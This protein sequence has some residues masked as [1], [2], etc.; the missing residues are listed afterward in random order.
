M[1]YKIKIFFLISF[2]LIPINSN[3]N[4]IYDKNN[5]IISTIDLNYY[6][7]L[8]FENYGLE[9]NES[10]AIKNIV[11]IKNIIK[12]FKKN[13]PNFLKKI[14]EV[15]IKEYGNE[16]MKIQIYKD[17]SRYFKIKNEFIYEFY[18]TK[19]DINHLK[20]IFNSL[21]KI[22]LPISDNN[23]LTILGLKDLKYDI[24]FLNNFYEN[25]KMESKK[26]ETQINN[27]K[28]RVCIDSRTYKLFE[29]EILNYIDT[30]TSD[31]FKKFVYEQ[32]Q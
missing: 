26:Y 29:N 3:S 4:I 10:T 11:I 20:T 31:D 7:Q 24:Y 19:F 2:L 9:L 27:V 30:E 18:Q 1:V 28:Y 15:L 21:D 17:F 13:N 25:L 14:D 6:K 5:I 22:E 12:Y 8:Y 32:Q 23:C 16:K